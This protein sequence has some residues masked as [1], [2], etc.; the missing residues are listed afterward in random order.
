MFLQPASVIM[1]PPS[2]N[3]VE[4]ARLVVGIEINGEAEKGDE[5]DRFPEPVA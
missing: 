3:T 5:P 1:Q 4:M 2:L